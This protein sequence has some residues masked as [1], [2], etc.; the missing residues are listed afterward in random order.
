MAPAIAGGN[1]TVT[2]GSARYP[3][4]TITFAEV[5]N[6]SD[7]PGGVCNL[8]TGRRDELLPAHGVAHGRQRDRLLR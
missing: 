8:L 7:V 2:L 5:L 1:T 3:L 4:S 6:S